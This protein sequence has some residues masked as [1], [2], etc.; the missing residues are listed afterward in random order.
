MNNVYATLLHCLLFFN[1]VHLFR[2]ISKNIYL[3][4][5]RKSAKHSLQREHAVSVGMTESSHD[6]HIYITCCLLFEIC[7]LDSKETPFREILVQSIKLK[8]CKSGEKSDFM[9]AV[10]VGIVHYSEVNM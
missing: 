2:K 7:Q 4:I 3:F 5:F 6:V 8:L 1:D 10:L 9:D